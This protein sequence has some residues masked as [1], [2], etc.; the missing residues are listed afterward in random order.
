MGYTRIMEVQIRVESGRE[1]P[2]GE[3]GYQV[4]N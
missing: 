3:V 1:D 2:T 4:L